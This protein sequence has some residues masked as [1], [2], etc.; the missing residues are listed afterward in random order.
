MIF[1]KG[2]VNGKI[3]ASVRGYDDGQGTAH[4]L[5]LSALPY[6]RGRGLGRRLI[7]AIEAEFPKAGRYEIF[8]G[9]RSAANIH[10]YEKMG[11]KRFKT[12]P[13]NANVEWVYM[14]KKPS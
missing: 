3:A 14:E 4:I 11:Y 7:S 6:F 8:T 12:E 1:L 13:F 10:I 2:L 5:R 9:H